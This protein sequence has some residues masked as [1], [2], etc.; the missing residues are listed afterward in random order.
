MSSIGPVKQ[1]I[2][3]IQRHKVKNQF[4]VVFNFLSL[5][6]L[7][8]LRIHTTTFTAL[9]LVDNNFNIMRFEFLLIGFMR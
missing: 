1:A 9:F 2:I 5:I 8:N 3:L 7:F 4:M 6:K